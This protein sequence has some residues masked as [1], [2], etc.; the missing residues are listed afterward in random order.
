ML[1]LSGHALG[2]RYGDYNGKRDDSTSAAPTPDSLFQSVDGD[3]NDEMTL[4]E[5]IGWVSDTQGD[6]ANNAT[7]L[8][9]WVEKFNM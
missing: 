4:G 3:N 7:L 6:V 9:K 2:C 8:D 5:Y 1:I